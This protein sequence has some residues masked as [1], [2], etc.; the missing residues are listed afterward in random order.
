[1]ISSAVPVQIAAPGLITPLDAL[2]YQCMHLVAAFLFGA[3]R[4]E[5]CVQGLM[6][7]A[8]AYFTA[9]R[10]LA[11]FETTGKLLLSNCPATFFAAAFSKAKAETF[12]GACF[13]AL[14]A[15][16]LGRRIAST[17][18]IF[19]SPLA[20]GPAFFFRLAAFETCGQHLMRMP[21]ANLRTFGRLAAF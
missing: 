13:A 2:F 16:Q 3:S 6:P 1:V 4:F 21:L 19:E 14:P 10:R 15:S 5:A 18:A 20:P 11:A 9:V 17:Q 12:V 8:T 7:M